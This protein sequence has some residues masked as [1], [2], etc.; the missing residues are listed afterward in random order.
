MT[1]YY[2][3]LEALK[4]RPIFEGQKVRVICPNNQVEVLHWTGSVWSV[5]GRYDCR[6][7]DYAFTNAREHA[8]RLTKQST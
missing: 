5:V 3:H 8:E 1:Q 6:S 7:D 2:E 4:F